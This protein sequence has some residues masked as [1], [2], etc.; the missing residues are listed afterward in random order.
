M[1]KLSKAQQRNLALI[2]EAGQVTYTTRQTYGR[3]R[4]GRLIMKGPFEKAD[5]KGFHLTALRSL[6]KMGLVLVV[7]EAL[8]DIG[9]GEGSRRIGSGYKH[10][11]TYK[12]A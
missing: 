4:T 1:I 8:E 2:R 12:P 6:V 5:Q 11:W 3:D 7:D 10:T 9:H